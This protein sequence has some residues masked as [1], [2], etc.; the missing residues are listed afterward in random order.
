MAG[1]RPGGEEGQPAFL[2]HSLQQNCP[3]HYYEALRCAGE[4]EIIL[5]SWEKCCERISD[6]RTGCGVKARSVSMTLE[7]A[8]LH[9]L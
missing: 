6:C 2:F 7:N 8:I 1:K 5:T 4:L 9:S 3:R